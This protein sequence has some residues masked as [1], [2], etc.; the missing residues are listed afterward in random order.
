[1]RAA[2]FYE[3]G[4]PEVIEIAEV[5]APERGP[6]DVRVAVRAVA[7][8]HLDLWVRRGLPNLSLPLPHVGGSDVAGVVDAVGEEVGNV[9]AGDEVLVNPSLPCRHCPECRTGET[10]LCRH[11]RILGEHVPGGLAE[12]VVVPADRVHPKPGRLSF[13][14]AAAVPLAFQTAWRALITRAAVKPGE[15]VVILGASGGV[16]TAAVQIARLAGARVIAVTSSAER[17]SAVEALGAEVVIDRTVEPW[18]KAAWLATGRRGADVVVENVGQATWHD[19]LRTAARGGRI[20][21]YGATTGP[22][23]ETDIRYIYWKQLSILGTTMSTDAEFEQ[24]LRLVDRGELKPVV[25]QV[26]G[27]EQA[28][29]A[30]AVLEAGDVI[31]KVVLAVGAQAPSE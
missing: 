19:S 4:G 29:R 10:P 2:V 31:G 16:A 7:L 26:L 9:Q 27:F 23:A 22:T 17:A 3:H 21:T 1:M 8:N 5:P 14:E 11:Y 28:A 15:D 6:R 12:Y 25:G 18:S 13:V 20:V 30:H 24:V